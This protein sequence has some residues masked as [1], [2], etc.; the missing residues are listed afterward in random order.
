MFHFSVNSPRA[1]KDCNAS[2][3]QWKSILRLADMWKF[4]DI[5]TFVI[6][7]LGDLRMD[8]LEKLE[9]S[10]RFDIDQ[11]WADDALIALVDREKPL[12]V[13][14]TLKVGVKNSVLIAKIRE[15]CVQAKLEKALKGS[16]RAVA[17][18]MVGKNTRFTA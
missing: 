13:D 3:K 1:Y 7:K 15:E 11:P 2:L 5:R 4:D 16:N 10:K 18:G 17:R 14:E 6:N 9:L 8:P 12:T